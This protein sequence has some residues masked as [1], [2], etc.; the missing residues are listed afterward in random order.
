MEEN[1]EEQVVDNQESTNEVQEEQ[2]KTTQVLEDGTYRVDLSM[3]S[4]EP[5]EAVQPEPEVEAVQEQPE[6]QDVPVV[7]EVTDEPETEVQ[8]EQTIEQPQRE[9][10]IEESSPKQELPEAIQKLVEFMDETGG[11]IEDYARLN[12]DYSGVDDKALLAEYYKS[13]KPHLT[14]DE[15]DFII[16]DKFQYD[17]DMDDERDIRRKQLAYKE[18]IAQAKSHLEGMKSKYYQ[19]LKLGSKLTKDQQQAVEFFNRYNEEQKQVEELTTKQ[20]Q[21]FNEQTNKIF[22]QDFK[23]FDFKIGDKKFRYNVKDVAETKEAQSNV[24][25]VFSKYV[26]NNN[27]L[28]DAKGY[29]KS[30]FA[31]R[32]PDALA[33]HFYEQGKADAVKEMTSQA[34]NINVDNR[35]TNDGFVQAGGTKVRVVSGENSSSTKLRLKN[36]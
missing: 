28:S 23:G 35:K 22:S 21:H 18:E 2:P 27:L 13:T 26:D 6:E 31:A 4:A 29:H 5:T 36:Y 11:S 14:R 8:V 24:L 17:E 15:I 34:K 10:V 12:A 9:E 20:Q 25:N 30:L 32:N 1:I 33:N 7:E 16:E 19:E 3:A